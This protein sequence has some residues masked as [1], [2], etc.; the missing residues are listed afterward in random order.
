MPEGIRRRPPTTDTFSLPQGQDEF[1]FALP[2]DKLDLCLWGLNH[3]LSAEIVAPS[4]GLT[5]HEVE[6]IYKDIQSKRRANL[7]PPAFPD[8]C[9]TRR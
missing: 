3:E 5:A 1:Y 4:V 9:R 6:R 8:A 2:Y 7:L